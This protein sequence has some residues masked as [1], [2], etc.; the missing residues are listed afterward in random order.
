MCEGALEPSYSQCQGTPS[1][2]LLETET[3]FAFADIGPIAKGRE[4]TAG[5]SQ[6]VAE[7]TCPS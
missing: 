1:F 2:K 3:A 4:C 5:A 6:T 7:L